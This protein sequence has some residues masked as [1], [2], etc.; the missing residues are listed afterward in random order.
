MCIFA[1]TNED[2]SRLLKASQGDG[3]SAQARRITEHVH[4][5]E[6]GGRMIEAHLESL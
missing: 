4:T 1:E 5:T 3:S 2:P 6:S